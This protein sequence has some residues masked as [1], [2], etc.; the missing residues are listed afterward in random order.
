M[1]WL[2]RK[3]EFRRMLLTLNAR[4][5]DYSGPF[6]FVTKEKK[7][8]KLHGAELPRFCLYLSADKE[9]YGATLA[10]PKNRYDKAREGTSYGMCGVLKNIRHND[11]FIITEN[12]EPGA[13]VRQAVKRAWGEMLF[14][15]FVCCLFLFS[16]MLFMIPLFI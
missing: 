15:L 3:D 8:V 11:F 16:I 13:A 7:I 1:I 14:F 12:T 4:N 9:G 5:L 10:V 2:S 6:R